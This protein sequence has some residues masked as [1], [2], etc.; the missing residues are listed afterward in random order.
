MVTRGELLLSGGGKIEG[1]E[2]LRQHQ[3]RSLERSAAATAKKTTV[4]AAAMNSH[5]DKA[6]PDRFSGASS[7]LA[8]G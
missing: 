2:S 3:R 7:W 8:G 5:H 6:P 1:R 4:C